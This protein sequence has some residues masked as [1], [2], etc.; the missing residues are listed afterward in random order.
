[1]S[2][3]SIKYKGGS[4][5]SIILVIGI[6][7][8][9]NFISTR[10]FFRIDLTD[11]KE[12]TISR[13]SKELVSGLDDMVNITMYFSK[14]LPPYLTPLLRQIK[15]IINEYR[16]YS[17]GNILIK[18]E[19][20][21]RDEK[22]L[23]RVRRMGIPEV[24]LNIIQK[25]KREVMNVFLGIAIQYEDKVEPIPVVQNTNNLEY[26]LTAVIM[27][28]TSDEVKT[29]G[30]TTGHDEPTFEEGF[31]E[32]KKALEKQYRVV[33]VETKE[34]KGV[35]QNVDTLI[36]AGPKKLSERDKFEID[37]FIMRGGKTMFLIDPIDRKEG[38][39]AS[40]L[41]T[42]IDDLLSHYGVKIKQE[43]VLDRLNANASFSSGFVRFSLPYPFWPRV[44]RKNFDGSHPIVN[45]LE[46]LV[47][48]WTG[49]LEVLD[50][51]LKENKSLVLANSSDSAWT[52][53]RFFNLNPQQ[54]FSPG[55]DMKSY[56]LAVVISGNFQ[57]FYAGKDIPEVASEGGGETEQTP[58]LK[59]DMEDKEVKEES[60]ETR[61][62][63]VGNS[64]F[65]S[66]QMVRQFRG[67]M[68]FFINAVDWLT[69]GEELISIRSRGATERP[70]KEISERKKAIVKF[71]D[72][73][74]VS[75]ILISFGMGRFYLRR[76]EKRLFET[77][78]R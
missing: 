26:D 51:N 37:Q 3:R 54:R 74:G 75:I 18:H 64:H 42:E 14:E 55:P 69:L 36:V 27:K 57:S 17:R 40:T 11:E 13:A 76:R 38:I 72:T 21:S 31:E 62:I 71:I 10:H 12:F 59:E 34:G 63:V 15:D 6:L 44:I 66:D 32:V 52:Q 22:T 45:R 1:M 33:E 47:L 73:F 56:P 19:D 70:L 46:S 5:L 24:Q 43:L 29:I 16:A 35:P 25:D 28:V 48:P 41:K 20:P 65:I 23:Q 61:I 7:M 49:P 77:M 8:V 50:E 67:N 53:K 30:F 78:A 58:E 60:P 9:L 68:T 4:V 2:R 39:R